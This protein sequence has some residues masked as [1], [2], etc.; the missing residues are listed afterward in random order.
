[1]KS[2]ILAALAAASVLT[3]ADAR[4][5][6][7][8][9]LTP[10]SELFATSGASATPMI[11]RF[12]P[13]QR[14][15][16]QAT[17]SPDAGQTITSVQFLVDGVAVGGAVT[18]IPA[19]VAGLPA[20]TVVATVR[21]YSNVTAGTHILTAQATQSDLATIS[22]NGN[23]EVVAIQNVGRKAKNVIIMLGDGMGSG[24]RT[25]ARIV[26]NGVT[27]GKA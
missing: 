5:L 15:D 17:V 24:H 27:Q 1:M 25:A 18:I 8:S 10:P 19:T 3:A 22:A 23:F 21:A 9:R 4:A 14:F 13:G 2:R 26:T 12:A 16:L 6:V 11:A 20:N 7:I